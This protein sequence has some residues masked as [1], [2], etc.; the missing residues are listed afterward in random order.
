[1]NA[2]EP[3]LMSSSGVSGS[4]TPIQYPCLAKALHW[5]SAIVILWAMITGTYISIFSVSQTLKDQI[6]YINVSVTAVF[7]PVFGLRLLLRYVYRNNPVYRHSSAVKGVHL[8]MYFLITV[9]L[10]SGVL[11]MHK[12]IN[13]FDILSLPVPIQSRA[14]QGVFDV[15]HV[16]GCRTLGLIV[17]VHIFAV[18]WHRF[19]GESVLH[20]MC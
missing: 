18:F 16:W 9:V 10:I 2:S 17:V 11:M 5:L 7:I 4:E 20:K 19:R 12:P 14:I 15:V 13:I 1:M 6:A 3:V 8:L